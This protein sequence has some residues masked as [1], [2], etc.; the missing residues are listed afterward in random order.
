MHY[1]IIGAGPAG[2]VAAE[3]LRK[4]DQNADITLIGGEAES[5]YSRM[6]IP[7]FLEGKIEQEGS[8][9]RDP[10]AHY[11]SLN[12]NL[13]QDVVTQVDG[14]GQQ[15][16]LKSGSNL[17]FDKLLIATGSSP[18][19]PPIPGTDHQIV[20]SC[21]TLE[22]ARKII[23]STQAGSKVVLIGAGFIGCIILESLFKR[24]VDLT[25][26]ETGNRMV[27]RMMND[28]AGGLLKKWCLNKGVKV[29][30]SC[31][32]ESIND[33]GDGSATVSLSNGE[34]LPAE[35]I[36]TATGVTSNTG[37]LKGSGVELDQGVKVDE[38]LQT[39]DANIYAAGD[40]A[41]GLDFSTGLYQVHA[42]QTTATDHGK[43]AALNM[44]GKS[45]KFHGSINMNVL[46]TLGLI[47]CS[48]GLWMG[49]EGGDSVE[50]FNADDFKYLNLQFV[51]DVLVG[52]SSVG[53]TQHIGVLRG[54]IESKIKLGVWKQRLLKDPTLIMEAFMA[55]T[56]EIGYKG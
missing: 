36:I 46:D 21:W 15:I 52:A 32:V 12:I 53:M 47:S 26:V 31:Q 19:V 16:S 1:I 25:V 42:I 29:L 7:Y 56:Q 38:Y 6:A 45:V 8:Y 20:N 55:C 24:G 40:V 27:P 35:F 2:V 54:L 3:T 11:S 23:A 33:A 13:L 44:C 9:L 10:D 49:G 4:N 48:F 37:F 5:P 34:T 43:I 17:K 30:T 51:D 39:S 41:Q 28:K 22:D 14:S 18:A 50:L